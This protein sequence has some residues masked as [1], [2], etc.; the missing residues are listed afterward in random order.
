MMLRPLQDIAQALGGDVTKNSVVAPGPGHLCERAKP[1]PV[2]YTFSERLI[3]AIIIIRPQ[4][5]DSISVLPGQKIL[6][7]SRPQIE[8]RDLVDHIMDHCAGRT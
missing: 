8:G 6:R 3:E 5:I 2:G 4:E 1:I 7:G